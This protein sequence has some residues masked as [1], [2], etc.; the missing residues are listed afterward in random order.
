[1]WES[2]SSEYIGGGLLLLTVYL[3]GALRSTGE[4]WIS[5]RFRRCGPKLGFTHNLEKV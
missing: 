4:S 2:I 1:M 5:E 3:I